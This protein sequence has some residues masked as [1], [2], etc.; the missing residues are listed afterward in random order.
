MFKN[1]NCLGRQQYNGGGGKMC[2]KLIPMNSNS[3][4]RSISYLHCYFNSLDD[5]DTWLSEKKIQARSKQ[6]EKKT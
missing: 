6:R 4:S 2:G 3:F 5:H 1:S